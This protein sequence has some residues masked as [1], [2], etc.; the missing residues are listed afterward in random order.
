[1]TSDPHQPGKGSFP[2]AA[3]LPWEWEVLK[4]VAPSPGVE[5]SC[6]SNRGEGAADTVIPLAPKSN[7]KPEAGDPI[8]R[9]A[10]DERWATGEMMSLPGGKNF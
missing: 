8:D 10:R 5:W 9:A 3:E 4:F 2:Q 1:M 7:T 6:M